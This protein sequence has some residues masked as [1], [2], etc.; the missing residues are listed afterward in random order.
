MK[1][2]MPLLSSVFLLVACGGSSAGNVVRDPQSA[3]KVAKAQSR[4]TEQQKEFESAPQDHQ[5]KC[6]VKVGDC[7]MQID[8]N[9]N[10][11]VANNYVAECRELP[12][13][14]EEAKC[15]TKSLVAD[16]QPKAPVDFY[17]FGAWCYEKL[18]QCTAG[19]AASAAEDERV[20][21]INARREEIEFSK[22]GVQARAAAT[23]ATERVS[24]I[25]STLPPNADGLC[26]EQGPTPECEAQSKIKL[27]RFEASL[28]RTDEEYDRQ[29]AINAYREAYENEATCHEAEFECLEASLP[30]Y[31]EI[32]AAKK[33]LE[34]NFSRLE[35]REFLRAQVDSVEGEQCLMAGVSEHQASIIE[36]Y[37][38]YVK[39]PVMF[40]RNRLHRAFLDL[41]Q[42]QIRCLEQ[43]ANRNR[44]E[45][46]PKLVPADGK[47]GE[48]FGG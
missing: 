40:F 17:N 5:K 10:D 16:G 24:Y 38:E 30:K 36:G 19:L 18:N 28:D 4:W 31:G 3:E 20:A 13:T 7:L 27:E 42:T 9:R 37:Q 11:F 41:H 48:R 15:I 2:L 46:S 43:A 26:A 25:R 12:N 34:K 21:K 8:E 6:E 44:A 1:S 39:Q 22:D 14:D 32:L 45:R 29:A 47:Q 33:S 23:F 35:R